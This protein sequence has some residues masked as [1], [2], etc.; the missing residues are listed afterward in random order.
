MRRITPR[1]RRV[2]AG[3]VGTAT[4]PAQ[5][6]GKGPLG[7]GS[8]DAS[9][10]TFWNDTTMSPDTHSGPVQPESSPVYCHRL[11][12]NR[13]TGVSTSSCPRSSY[14]WLTRCGSQVTGSR[15]TTLISS[16]RPSRFAVTALKHGEK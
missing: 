5:R 3:P 15:Y 11:A 13:P 12:V 1:Y 9:S 14:R 2:L 4:D 10:N 8:Y 16:V 6:S 7:P